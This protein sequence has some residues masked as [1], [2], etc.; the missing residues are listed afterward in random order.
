MHFDY[1]AFQRSVSLAERVI[2][3]KNQSAT[4][5]T[6]MILLLVGLVLSTIIVFKYVIEAFLSGDNVVVAFSN[7]FFLIILYGYLIVIVVSYLVSA[8]DEIRM[9]RFAE[10]NG[11]ELFKGVPDEQRAGMIFNQG[12]SRIMPALLLMKDKAV[13]ELGVYRYATGSGKSHKTY[14]YTFL[15]MKLPRKLPHIVLDAKKNNFL[16]MGNLPDVL[17][18]AQRLQLEGDF[19]EH[20]NLYVPEGYERDALYIFTPD[21]MQRMIDAT[22]NYDSEIVDDDLFVFRAGKLRLSDYRQVEELMGIADAIHAKLSSQTNYYADER[23]G[24]RSLNLVHDQGRRLKK[25]FSLAMVLMFLLF[26]VY[27]IL[28]FIIDSSPK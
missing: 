20:F 2:Y 10:M 21:V 23:V 13:S 22:S 9:K 17:A 26:T 4:H 19:N 6:I 12:H 11:I 5:S 18:G 8:G 25:G 14:N 7:I 27:Y 16:G 28:V 24:D 1:S 3:K 15:R